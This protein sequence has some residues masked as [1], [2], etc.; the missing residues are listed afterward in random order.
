MRTIEELRNRI[1]WLQDRALNM[2]KS[3]DV[4]FTSK[5]REFFERDVW[6]YQNL[7][8]YMASLE[9]FDIDN[10][11]WRCSICNKKRINKDI[12]VAKIEIDEC[13][14]HN[15]KY[16]NDDKVCTDKAFNWKE[17]E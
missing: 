9:K 5:A 7:L 14:T 17:P 12:S 1:V 11:W 6:I 10:M 2:T 16:C 13:V 15:I 8:D 3:E 4:L